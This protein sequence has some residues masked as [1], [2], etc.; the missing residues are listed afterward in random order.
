M[1]SNRGNKS[2]ICGEQTGSSDTN[3][4]LHKTNLTNFSGRKSIRAFHGRAIKPVVAVV[5]ATIIGACVLI[6]S[7]CS[8]SMG[9]KEPADNGVTLNV[10]PDT[11]KVPSAFVLNSLVTNPDGRIQL[12]DRQL[13]VILSQGGHAIAET[14]L[15]PDSTNTIIL[16]PEIVGNGDIKCRVALS[17]IYEGVFEAEDSATIVNETGGWT[18]KPISHVSEGFVDTVMIHV[19]DSTVDSTAL[20]TVT[21]TVVGMDDDNVRFKITSIDF[22][23]NEHILNDVIISQ[24]EA[25]FEAVPVAGPFSDGRTLYILGPVINLDGT[26][27]F[28]VV[29]F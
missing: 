28:Q 9:P 21:L 3:S 2:T 29:L 24:D 5:V 10:S 13:L 4:N 15:V 8:K 6:L 16:K 1:K 14:T 11:V 19:A 18:L 27:S 7:A 25:R 17:N 12:D 22:E 20:E 26:T 23:G